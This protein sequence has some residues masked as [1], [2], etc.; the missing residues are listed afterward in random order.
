MGHPYTLDLQYFSLVAA[1]VVASVDVAAAVAAVVGVAAVVAS[2]AAAV[3]GILFLPVP[4]VFLLVYCSL[5]Q[6]RT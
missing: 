1:A 3:A 2:A 5:Q 4:L 6:W